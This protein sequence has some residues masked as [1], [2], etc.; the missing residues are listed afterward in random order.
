MAIRGAWRGMCSVKT[1]HKRSD[2]TWFERHRL[3]VGLLVLSAIAVLCFANSLQ[4]GFTFDDVD[5]IVNNVLIRDLGNIGQIM[6]SSWWWGGAVQRSD[7]YRP[8]TVLSFAVNYAVHKL[9]PA[10][11]HMLNVL[12]HA[13]VTAMIFLFVNALSGRYWLSLVAALLYAT[14]PI[15]T[16]PVNNIVGRA[17]I[18]AALFFFLTVH[19]YLVFVVRKRSRWPLFY[20]L[21]LVAYFLGILSKETA[22][23]AFP[24]IILLDLMHAR[25]GGA[26]N[27]GTEYILS[28]LKQRLPLY[29]GFIGV[30]IVYLFLRVNALGGIKSD[31][32]TTTFLD[33]VLY[34]ARGSGEHGAMILTAIKIVGMYMW[35]LLFPLR[36]SADY[37]FHQISLSQSIWD[38]AVLATLLVVFALFAVT[39][40]AWQRR[41]VTPAFAILLFFIT[42]APVSNLFIL[43]G[44]DM[45]ERLLYL[46]SA[47]FCL[48][49]AYALEQGIGLLRRKVTIS[50]QTASTPIVLLVIA[51]LLGGAYAVRTWIRNYDW[52]NDFRVFLS[53]TQVSPRCARAH[54]NLGNMYKER[55]DLEKAAEHYRAAYA[56]APNY[57][58]PL[59][60]LGD[61]LLQQGHTE[62]AIAIFKQ[63]IR[64][65]DRYF[66]A[67]HNLGTAYAKLGQREDAVREFQRTIELR[68]TVPEPYFNIGDI[69]LEEK[70]FDLAE[71][72]FRKALDIAPGF[73]PAYIRLGALCQHTQRPDEALKFFQAAARLQPN[74]PEP[75]LYLGNLYAS[76]GKNDAAREAFMRVI[77]LAPSWPEGHLALAKLYLIAYNDRAKARYHFSKALELN[78]NHPLRQKILDTLEDLKDNSP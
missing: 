58:A 39:Y 35:L 40:I 60:G 62:Q 10:G 68:P 36:L 71:Q 67:H 28:L 47:G 55:G 32:I 51:A 69:Y 46:P 56:I 16:E 76:Q 2:Q 30:V 54:F 38:P 22:I 12:L 17:E 41:A 29:A 4:N 5:M 21:S 63:V 45:G 26:K 78:P 59:N 13:G 6:T 49:V 19:W 70:R 37:S 75:F 72:Y 34:L 14:H 65:E 42:L 52:Q 27:V 64:M 23:T 18:L 31:T 43:I 33:N 15:H 44:T 48:L 74:H 53:A 57:G 61:I 3:V 24:V 9:K 50:K 7:E 11:Y 73:Y 77:E 1:E 8:L 66:P 20:G 25:A